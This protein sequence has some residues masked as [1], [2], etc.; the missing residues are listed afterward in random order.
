ME[1]WFLLSFISVLFIGYFKLDIKGYL[2]VGDILLLSVLF[3][4]FP[5]A[6][7]MVLVCFILYLI[8][9]IRNDDR[10]KIKFIKKDKK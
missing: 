10:F 4:L 9:D 7:I 6:I 2:N 3:I 8:E 1:F 5:L